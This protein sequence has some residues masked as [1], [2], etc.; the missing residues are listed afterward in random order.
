MIKY[1]QGVS[2]DTIDAYMLER[3]RNWRNDPRIW[4]YCRQHDLIPEGDHRDWF[5]RQRKDPTIRMYAV[6][7]TEGRPSGVCGLTEL[8]MLNRRAEFSLYIDPDRQGKGLGKKALQTLLTHGFKNLGLNKIWG[9]VFDGNPAMT[10]FTELGMHYAGKLVDH[11]FRDGKFINAHRVE[12]TR[13][14]WDRLHGSWSE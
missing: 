8:D 1:F 4:Q 2:L 13:D 11:Y 7:D 14:E 12:M 5:E 10:M 9:E 6:L 3:M